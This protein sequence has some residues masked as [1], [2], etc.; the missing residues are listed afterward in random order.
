MDLVKGAVSDQVMGQIGGLLG[1]DAKT[2]SLFETAAGSI[3]G[4]LMKKGA[5]AQGAQDIFGAVQKQDDSILDKLGDLLGGGNA[6]DAYQEQGSGILDMVLGGSQQ[7]S[8]LINTV[9]SALGLDKGIVGKLL[10]MAAPVVMGVI[11]KHIKNKALDAVGL[12]NLL[13]EQK[14]H[15]AGLM[16]SSLTNDLGFGDLLGNAGKVAG[17]AADAVGNVGDAVGN[18]GNAASSAGGSLLKY[19]IPVGIVAALAIFGIPK[20][21]EYMSRQP[22]GEVDKSQITAKPF[23]GSEIPGMD[24]GSIPGIDELGE[25]GTKLTTGFADIA[26]GIK[27]VS[28]EAGATK[29]ADKIT[30]F[31]GDFDAL[32]LDKLEG[33]SKAAASGIVSN[34]VEAIKTMLGDKSEDIRGILKPVIDTLMEKLKPFIGEQIPMSAFG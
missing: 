15:L 19:V 1:T 31:T 32:G 3:L 30:G 20:L 16:P 17:S 28:D 23:A 26:A 4:G 33:T 10:M 21:I 8:G 18:V 9:A 25:T 6:T 7:T 5:T 24:F 29:L 13:G 22:S 27:D 2:P 11:G 14:S 34:A 12:G